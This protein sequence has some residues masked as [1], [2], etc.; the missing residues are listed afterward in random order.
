MPQNIQMTIGELSSI[1]D[2]LNVVVKT[3]MKAKYAYKFGKIAKSLQV[4]MNEFR[5]NR[6]ALIR[7]YGK[8]DGD[9]IKVTAEN[10][11]KYAEE[12]REMASKV[13]E[14]DFEPI[15]VSVLGEHKF[16]SL[17]MVGLEKFF[18]D[19]EEVASKQP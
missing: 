10:S 7:K 13:I 2:S 16:T 14:L 6:D 4:H 11:S 19:D 9:T 15:P 8:P 3:P 17:D 12:I 18:Y 1:I 5:V